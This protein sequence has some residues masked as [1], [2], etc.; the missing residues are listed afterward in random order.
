MMSL[1][2]ALALAKNKFCPQAPPHDALMEAE[3]EATYSE[4]FEEGIIFA[5]HRLMGYFILS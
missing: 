2:R 5:H 4:A 3:A 1:D